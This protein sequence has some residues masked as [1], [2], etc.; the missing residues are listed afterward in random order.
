M[1]QELFGVSQTHYIFHI[2]L[3]ARLDGGAAADEGMSSSASLPRL[4]PP[5]A[6][7]PLFAEDMLGR[8]GELNTV[9]RG[10]IMLIVHMYLIVLF[11][12]SS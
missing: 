10:C 1:R 6:G 8:S 5:A 12:Q 11:A 9:S 4:R 7:R 2:A 3:H